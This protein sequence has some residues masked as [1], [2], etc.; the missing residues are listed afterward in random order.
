V[1]LKAEEFFFIEQE[2]NAQAINKVKSQIH[3]LRRVY[4][5]GV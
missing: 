2:D 4:R 5:L 3:V 1:L